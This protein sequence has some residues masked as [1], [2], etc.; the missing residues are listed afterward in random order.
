VVNEVTKP[1]VDERRY[2]EDRFMEALYEAE[3]AERFMK[4]GLLRNAAGKAYQ[5]LKAY[6]AGLSVDYRGLLSQYFPGRRKITPTKTVER[7]DWVIAIMPSGRLREV[8]AIIGDRD[9]RLVTEVAI[10][11]HEF[12]YNGFDRDVEVSRHSRE[13]FVRRDISLVIDFIRGRLSHMKK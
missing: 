12:Q 7:V 4:D 11:L 13:E 10:N 8:A 5:A 1:W 6:V 3:L 9:L 2:Q